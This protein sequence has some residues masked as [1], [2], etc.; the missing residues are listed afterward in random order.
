[1]ARKI[2]EHDS[3]LGMGGKLYYEPEKQDAEAEINRLLETADRQAHEIILAER[4][5][6]TNWRSTARSQTLTREEFWNSSIRR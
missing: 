1:M 6:T 5:K 3:R 2:R 4:D